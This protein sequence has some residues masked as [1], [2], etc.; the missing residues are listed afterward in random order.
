MN[1]HKFQKVIL[2]MYK[3][4]CSGENGSIRGGSITATEWFEPIMNIFTSKCSRSLE[5]V[6]LAASALGSKWKY[7]NKTVRSPLRKYQDILHAGNP[8]QHDACP[9][10]ARSRLHAGPWPRTPRHAEAQQSHNGDC[11][12]LGERKQPVRSPQGKEAFAPLSRCAANRS[13]QLCTWAQ[14]W[15][16]SGGGERI[17]L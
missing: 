15:Q 9:F 12:I 3:R 17:Q 16:N 13:P 7:C 14:E 6:L 2:L 5:S 4:Y 1:I 11:S 8:A 10:G